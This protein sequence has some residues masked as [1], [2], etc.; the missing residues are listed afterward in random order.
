M[1]MEERSNN[2]QERGARD[3][4]SNRNENK[5]TR[6][7]DLP[8]SAGDKEKL[9]AEE[10]YIDLPDVKDIP[11]QEFVNAPPAGILGDTTISSADEEGTSVFDRDESKDLRS[12][13]N[14]SDV[15]RDERAALRKVDYLPTRDED[16]LERAS[17]DRTDF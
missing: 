7:N 3:P 11:G 2:S 6:P 9:K 14:E 10:T 16:N 15:T 1:F 17:M 4:H 12:T 13:G 8:D 5:S